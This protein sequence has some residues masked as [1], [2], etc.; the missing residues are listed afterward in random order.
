MKT[1]K[2]AVVPVV[3]VLTLAATGSVIAC[4]IAC[5]IAGALVGLF[6]GLVGPKRATPKGPTLEERLAAVEARRLSPDTSRSLTADERWQLAQRTPAQVAADEERA[7]IDAAVEK[8]LAER[9][10]KRAAQERQARID[11]AVAAALD[12][13]K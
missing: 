13:S 1:L 3:A 10:A 7:A 12:A 6:E 4:V 11:A 5:G 2:I 9:D 8:A